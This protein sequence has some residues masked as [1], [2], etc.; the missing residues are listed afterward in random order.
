MSL[1]PT[2]STGSTSY[3]P[4]RS[5]LL[6]FDHTNARGLEAN[7]NFDD[8]S[9]STLT[10]TI[11]SEEEE[12]TT[13][14]VI[15]LVLPLWCFILFLWMLP[16]LC[17]RLPRKISIMLERRQYKFFPMLLLFT[18]FCFMFTVYL[19]P[20]VQFNDVFFLIVHCISLVLTYTE[21]VVMGIVALILLFALWRFKDRVL[22]AMGVEDSGHLLG[23]WRD[24]VTCWSMSRFEPIDVWIWK[25]TDV[26]SAKMLTQNHVFIE[27][28]MGYNASIR[29]R[30]H[31]AAGNSCVFKE[32]IQLNFD[33]MDY[34]SLLVMKVLT[35]DMIGS[36]EIGRM[37]MG[38]AQVNMTIDHAGPP[39]PPESG[40]MPLRTT[41]G[42]GIFEEGL[43]T[44]MDLTPCGRLW[45]RLAPVQV[46]PDNPSMMATRNMQLW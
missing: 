12:A 22:A 21:T 23:D 37:S 26:P 31:E 16:C 24:W 19:L 17:S 32:R 28:S 41:A 7:T 10:T 8:A 39:L 42:A 27:T 29:T 11:G 36:T 18:A 44:P 14:A 1:E 34:S 38:C 40:A 2:P 25:V 13:M 15:V 43:F 46:A 5:S 6:F 45:I 33:P 4:Q 30:V 3:P 9:A 35:Q 20:G